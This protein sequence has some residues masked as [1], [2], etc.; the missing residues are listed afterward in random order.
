MVRF[1]ID[2]PNI[3]CYDVFGEKAAVLNMIHNGLSSLILFDYD[4]EAPVYRQ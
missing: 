1:W 4:E 2:R 3:P